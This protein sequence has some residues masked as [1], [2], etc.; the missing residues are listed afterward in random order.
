MKNQYSETGAAED[1]VRAFVQFGCAEI[2]A[3]SLHYKTTAEMEN[4]LVDVSDSEVLQ[5]QLEKLDMYQEDIDTYAGLRRNAMRILFQ[6]FEGGDKDAWCLVKHLGIGAMT[7]FE[8]YEASDNDPELL[9]LAY[10]ANAAFTKALSR[11][12]G[13]E[14]TTCAACFADALKGAEDGIRELQAN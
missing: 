7:A 4:G 6:M 8:T 10:E 14:I 2:H 11:F 1:L 3:M 9:N 5:K 13:V 12:L